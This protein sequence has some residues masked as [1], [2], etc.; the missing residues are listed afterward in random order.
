L[1]DRDTWSSELQ[2]AVQILVNE[3]DRA[4]PIAPELFRF[5]CPKGMDL[6]FYL[7]ILAI[8]NVPNSIRSKPKAAKFNSPPKLVKALLSHSPGADNVYKIFGV[9]ERSQWGKLIE[10]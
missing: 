4:N 8:A 9:T 1:G 5:G 10:T 6:G 2:A 3:L 7:R